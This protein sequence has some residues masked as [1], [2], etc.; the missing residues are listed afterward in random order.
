MKLENRTYKRYNFYKSNENVFTKGRR[1]NEATKES[2]A[3]NNGISAS[4]L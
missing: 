3:T 2:T 1:N 4:N